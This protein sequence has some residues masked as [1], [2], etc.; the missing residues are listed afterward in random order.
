MVWDQDMVS[1]NNFKEIDVSILIRTK[2]E[3]KYIDKILDAIFSQS[4]RNFEVLIV[5]SGSTDRTLEIEKNIL[6]ALID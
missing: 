1:D 3:E 4:H 6:Y 2:N 5:D